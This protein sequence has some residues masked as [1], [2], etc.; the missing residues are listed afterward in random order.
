MRFYLHS[1]RSRQIVSNLT[2]KWTIAR[3][4]IQDGLSKKMGSLPQ[5]QQDALSKHFSSL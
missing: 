2:Y 4:A 3:N 1:G 5:N